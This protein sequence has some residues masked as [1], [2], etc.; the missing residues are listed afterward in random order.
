MSLDPRFLPLDDDE[1]LY[2]PSGSILMSNPTFKVGEFLDALA[3]TVSDRESEWSEDHEGWFANGVECQ[4][5]RLTGAG[6]Q[7]GHVRLRLE[8]MPSKEPERLPERS[9]ARDD[10]VRMRAKTVSSEDSSGAS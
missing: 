8:F 4:V 9:T 2:V 7:H 3:Q 1:V 5:V 10:R 6:W